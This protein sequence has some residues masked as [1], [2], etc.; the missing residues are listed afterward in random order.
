MK[1]NLSVNLLVR[2]KKLDLSLDEVIIEFEKVFKEKGMPEIL[3][4]IFEN[5]DGLLVNNIATAIIPKMRRECC[6][7]DIWHSHGFTTKTVKTSMGK[8]KLRLKRMKCLCRTTHVPF[9][10]FFELNKSK[11]FSNELQKKCCE[12]I[13][14]QSYL[15]SVRE[16]NSIGNLGI[17]KMELYRIV[18]SCDLDF[19]NPKN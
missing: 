4:V 9:N 7:N 2:L 19:Q 5:I 13:C 16:L 3:E 11:N 14:N 1:Q 10:L 15:R 6:S 8:L 12:L 18:N 17:K